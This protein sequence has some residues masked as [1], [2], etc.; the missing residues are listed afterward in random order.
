MWLLS[1]RLLQ[2]DK[3]VGPSSI[4]YVIISR[5]LSIRVIGSLLFPEIERY[6]CEIDHPISLDCVVER[7]VANW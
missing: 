7:E 5:S 1:A 2:R 3:S 6:V 4:N